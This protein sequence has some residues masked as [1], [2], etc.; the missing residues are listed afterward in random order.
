MF[1]RLALP[2]DLPLALKVSIFWYLS[3]VLFQGKVA[4]LEST[5]FFAWLFVTWSL[6]KRYVTLSPH[7]LYL[8]LLLFGVVS[9]VSAVFAAHDIHGDYEFM[10][11]LKM[12]IFPTALI[13]FRSVPRVRDLALTGQ[14]V[15]GTYMATY[16]LVQFFFFGRR[17]LETRITGSSTHVMTYSGLLLPLALLMLVLWIHSRR[18]WLLAGA[19]MTSFA[20]LLTFTRSI[21]IGWL[22][23]VVA[24]ISIHRPRWFVWAAPALVVFITFMPLPLFGRL[25]STFDI[26]QSSNLDRVRMAEAGLEMIKDYPLLGVGPANVKEYYPLYR[27]HDAPRFRPPH[28]HNNV[29][30]LWAERGV[31][32]LAAYL[33]LLG[34]YLRECAKAWRGRAR[35]FAQAGVAMTVGLFAA[36]LF[37]FNFGDTEVFYLMLEMMALTIAFMEKDDGIE[38]WMGSMQEV[39][40]ANRS[41][42]PEVRIQN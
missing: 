5:A 17:E 11:W 6:G 13:L 10:L 37:E 22:A 30:Q 19:S 26:E 35:P 42:N 31:L 36:G 21:W 25:I 18:W 27:R 34:L 32:G 9:T 38:E 12:L 29:I 24:I 8:P 23:A 4:L 3:H 40:E 41:Q 39:R 28:L 14:L 15:F 2:T 33:M 20:L 7:I 1:R 16:G